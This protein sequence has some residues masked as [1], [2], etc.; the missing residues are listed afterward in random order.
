MTSQTSRRAVLGV[1]LAAGAVAATALPQATAATLSSLSPIDG[2][3]LDLWRRRIELDVDRRLPSGLDDGCFRQGRDQGG[4]ASCHVRAG[5]I[6]RI[7][8]SPV[9]PCGGGDGGE[10]RP[11]GAMRLCRDA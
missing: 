10:I 8:T 4:H 1:A 5:S 7:R 11:M 6:N 9:G 3:V 2:R